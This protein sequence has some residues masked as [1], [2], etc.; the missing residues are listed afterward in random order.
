MGSVKY[1]IL[2]EDQQLHA[3]ADELRAET[4]IAVDVEADSLHHYREKVCLIQISTLEKTWLVD[5]LALTD[6]G[7]L[8]SM[9][10]L[11]SRE[12]VLHGGD[13]D[14][15]SLNRDFGVRFDKVFDTMLAAQFSGETEIGLASLLQRYCKVTLDK[16]FQKAD[17]SLRPLPEAMA[18]YAAL[19]TAHLLFLADILKER[20]RGLGRL[21]WVEEE[22]LLLA[23]NRMADKRTGPL[24]LTCKGAG[25][26]QRRNLAVLEELLVIREE[27]AQSLDRPTFKVFSTDIALAV[28]TAMPTT[29]TTLGDISSIP[30]GIISR[31]GRTFLQAV[32]RG[33]AYGLS[34]LP[35]YPR[36]R[37]EANPGVKRKIALLKEWRTEVEKNIGLAGGLL[38]PNWLLERIAEQW[39]DSF[40]RLQTITG[41]RAWQCEVWG[42]D[43]LAF[44]AKERT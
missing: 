42:R 1:A 32:E 15:R 30:R 8:C 14:I 7:T 37:G 26:L 39:S 25:K 10:S 17:W 22:C 6:V 38:A 36:T 35:C 40:E 13:Y 5:P 33:H 21:G 16:R 44:I 19:D 11:R 24:F 9:L 20:L 41:I 31:Y 12:T 2:E 3:L 28:A 34:E 4:R 18:D 43:V 23:Q 29:L 27:I